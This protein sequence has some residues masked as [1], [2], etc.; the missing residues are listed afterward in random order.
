MRR[1]KLS[2][3]LAIVIMSAST[4]MSGC[5][6]KY[7]SNDATK[8]PLI[9][10]ATQQEIIDY[11][12]KAMEYDSIITRNVDVHET[13]YNIQDVSGAKEET[14]KNLVAK[15]E[16]ILAK[17][18]YEYLDEETNEDYS[19]VVSYDTYVYVKTMIDN[20]V[21]SNS[22]IQQIGGALGYYFVDVEYDISAKT[23]G[24]FNQFTPLVSLNG[25][26]VRVADGTY[27]IDVA[28]LQTAMNEINKY[29][30]VHNVNKCAMF[31]PEAGTF[32]I[33]DGVSPWSVS[34]DI[35]LDES[36]ALGGGS[37]SGSQLP[38]VDDTDILDGLGDNTDFGETDETGDNDEAGEAGENPDTDTDTSS[39]E[40]EPSTGQTTNE[41]K[42]IIKYDSITDDTRK[43]QIDIS[44][45]NQVVGT[46]LSARAFLPDLNL[47]YEKPEAEGT[48]SGF[49]IYPS[50]DSGLKL[51]GYD[52]SKF[53]GT[54]T[55]RY[56]FKDDT[57]ATGQILGN[58]IYILEEQIAT[59]PD[60]ADQNVV[61]PQFLEEQIGILVERM[62]RVIANRDLAG[63]VGGGVFEDMGIV[64]LNGYKDMGCNTLKHMSVVRQIISRDIENNAY[65]VELETTVTD[66]AA[67]TD[68]YA[69]YR[70]KYYV[71]VQQQGDKFVIS[72]IARASRE[73]ATEPQIS[74]DTATEKRMIALNLS[75]DVSED[76]KSDITQLMTDLYTASTNRVGTEP[77][78]VDGVLIEKSMRDCF[79]SNPDMLAETDRNYMITWLQNKLIKYGTDTKSILSGTITEWIGGYDNQVEFMTEELI[80][81]AGHSDGYH[82]SQVYYLASKMD[83][84]WVIDERK[85]IDDSDVEGT[86]LENIKQR[87][88]Q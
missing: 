57:E 80:T 43:P 61:V 75:G 66:G 77:K 58:N 13:K 71:V 24:K 60:V 7:V 48:I 51:F 81:Y 27:T 53:T 30:R 65:L 83:D 86:E 74:P 67:S 5:G 87:V 3:K 23:P 42:G 17:D 37:S 40:P 72:D 1:D 82:M 54:M 76:T 21:L 68:C 28:Y 8:Y 16:S 11:Y 26:F 4:L 12:A 29:Y 56:V 52:R 14:L 39:S 44:L 59:G 38:V 31:D 84:Y 10:A 45:I 22:R 78:E 41:T 18:E 6:N 62:D 64:V 25:S 63:M 20:E 47:V 9:P 73:V 70:D 50:G 19:K 85:V 36:T 46:S 55:L 88:G 32:E 69:T 79:N 34:V 15:A 2:I 33:L 49:G 35:G